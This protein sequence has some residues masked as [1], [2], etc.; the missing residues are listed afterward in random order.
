ML[1]T[2]LYSFYVVIPLE[3]SDITS[4]DFHSSLTFLDINLQAHRAFVCSISLS[5]Y[6]DI[7]IYIF[8]K[9]RH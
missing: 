1:E 6:S 4:I 3:Y 7:I 9:G 5:G 2:S 8:S